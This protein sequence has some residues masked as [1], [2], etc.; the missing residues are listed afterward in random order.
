MKSTLIT[1]DNAHLF[2]EGIPENVSDS[3]D[4]LLGVID[5]ETDT[6]CGVLAAIADDDSNLQI[7]FIYVAEPFRNK[8]AGKELL[9]SLKEIAK[10]AGAMEISCIHERTPISDGVYELLEKNGY[11]LFDVATVSTYEGSLSD[12]TVSEDIISS[13]ILPFSELSDA[14]KKDLTTFVN[15]LAKQDDYGCVLSLDE[16]PEYD[17]DHSFVCFSQSGKITGALLVG[18]RSGGISVEG[19]YAFGKNFEKTKRDLIAIAKEAV[20]EDYGPDIQVFMRPYTREQFQEMD[21]LFG[22]RIRKKEETVVQILT[23]Y[24]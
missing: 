5:E 1:E 15:K 8:G 24:D 10:D 21:M 7:T 17:K 23:I 4:L 20:E 22:K 19:I 13:I 11:G 12:I 18:V 6:A 14:Q 3:A 9:S 16:I 2:I